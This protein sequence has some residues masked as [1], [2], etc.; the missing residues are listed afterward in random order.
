M[1]YVDAQGSAFPSCGIQ[2]TSILKP[3]DDDRRQKT[4]EPWNPGRTQKFWDLHEVTSRGSWGEAPVSAENFH[5]VSFDRAVSVQNVVQWTC[6]VRKMTAGF[7]NNHDEQRMSSVPVWSVWSRYGN[8]A[9]DR[10]VQRRSGRFGK[11]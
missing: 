7:N 9:Q 11:K 2:S 10:L 6:R 5:I 8:L 4:A 1:L 3:A